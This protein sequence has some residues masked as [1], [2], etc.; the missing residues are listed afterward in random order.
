LQLVQVMLTLEAGTLAW[1]APMT[2]A[3]S[4]RDGRPPPANRPLARGR[5][6]PRRRALRA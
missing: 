1:E 6:G 3:G 2:L 5:P 4:G